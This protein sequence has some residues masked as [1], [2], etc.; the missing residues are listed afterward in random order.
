MIIEHSTGEKKHFL[1]LAGFQCGSDSGEFLALYSGRSAV[2]ECPPRRWEV[3]GLIP[4][5][6]IDCENGPPFL[7]GWIEVV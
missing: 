3:A 7:Q 6:V 5:W 1:L 4:S 2:V